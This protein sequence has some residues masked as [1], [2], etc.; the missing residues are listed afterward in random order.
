LA[1]K[2]SLRTNRRELF[3]DQKAI[4]RVGHD[5]VSWKVDC[6]SNSG[7]NCSGRFSRPQAR[8]GAAAHDQGDDSVALLYARVT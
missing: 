2:Y 6:G 7:R 4:L 3:G 5:D 8:S 1:G